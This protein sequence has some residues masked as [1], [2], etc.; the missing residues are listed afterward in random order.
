VA[1]SVGQPL[2]RRRRAEIRVARAVRDGDS[3][4]TLRFSMDINYEVRGEGF[5]DVLD[6]L[7]V[8]EVLRARCESSGALEGQRQGYLKAH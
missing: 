3:P 8:V 5:W 1:R 7:L 6:G 4:L 2:Q